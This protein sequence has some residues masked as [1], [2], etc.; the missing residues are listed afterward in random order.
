[1]KIA[2]IY[3]LYLSGLESLIQVQMTSVKENFEEPSLLLGILIWMKV[4]YV[5]EVKKVQMLVQEM[6]VVHWCVQTRQ[7]RT[8]TYTFSWCRIGKT[9]KGFFTI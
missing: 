2:D 7:I 1:M 8:G 6:E 5:Q 9:L 3:P 4:F